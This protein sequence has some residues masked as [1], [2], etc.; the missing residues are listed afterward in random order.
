[1]CLLTL[2]RK[3]E[4]ERERERAKGR[5]RNII[6]REMNVKTSTEDPAC[7]LGLCS[8]L[9][10]NLKRF[11]PQED[12]P[13]LFPSHSLSTTLSLKI[14]FKNI[15]KINEMVCPNLRRDWDLMFSAPYCFVSWVYLALNMVGIRAV[16]DFSFHLIQTKEKQLL[17]L[18]SRKNF[19]CGAYQ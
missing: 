10:S 14:N 15:L 6:V 1:M 13:S 9:E 19:L 8:D 16:K 2:E 7:S 17:Q 11:G 3:E 18:V 12:A 5:E 4:R